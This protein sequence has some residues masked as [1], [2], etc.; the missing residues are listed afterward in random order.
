MRTIAGMLALLLMLQ[1]KNIVPS[2]EQANLTKTALAQTSAISATNVVDSAA[3]VQYSVHASL[4]CTT[5]SAAATVN[6]TIRWTD[7]AGGGT[8]QSITLGSA[9]TCTTIGSASI[10]AL[11]TLI[12]PKVATAITY[13]TAIVNTPTYDVRVAIIPE[14]G[15]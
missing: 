6:I 12:A 1:V 14:T 3:A 10:G 9:V 7:A 15:N 13:E 8:A 11:Q 2:T 5:T 4:R